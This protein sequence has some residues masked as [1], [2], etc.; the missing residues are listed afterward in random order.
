[1]TYKTLSS[2]PQPTTIYLGITKADTPFPFVIAKP[3]DAFPIRRL[4]LSG[5]FFR[6]EPD[7][8]NSAVMKCG[9]K[10]L[11]SPDGTSSTV[12]GYV[13][14]A[15][16][17]GYTPIVVHQ[18][19]SHSAD[20]EFVADPSFHPSWIVFQAPAP[21]NVTATFAYVQAAPEVATDAVYIAEG[22]NHVCHP[23][24]PPCTVT[25]GGACPVATTPCISPPFLQSLDP[26]IA[27]R[28]DLLS[29]HGDLLFTR[30]TGR[31][32]E[33]P[34]TLTVQLFTG[35]TLLARRVTKPSDDQSLL[36]I[37]MNIMD[38]ETVHRTFGSQIAEHYVAVSLDIANR[39]AKKLQFNKSAVWFDV[40]YSQTSGRY[41]RTTGQT[42][43]LLTADLYPTNPYLT[44]FSTKEPCHINT[45]TGREKTPCQKFRFGIEQNQRVFPVNYTTVLNAFDANTEHLDRILRYVE[46]FGSVLDIVATGGVVAQINNTAFRDSAT[47]FT[48]NFLPGFRSVTQD[49]PG[50]N[51]MRANLVN[52][53]FQEVVQLSANGHAT[54]TVLLPRDAIADYQG[55]EQPVVIDRVLNVH[56]DPDVLNGVKDPPVPMNHVDLGYTKDQVRQSLGEPPNV[57]TAADGTSAYVYSAGPY[58]KVNF[59]KEGQA[60]SWDVRAIKD[61]L[62]AAISLDAANQILRTSNLKATQLLLLNKNTLLVGIDGMDKKLQYDSSGKHVDDYVELYPSIYK[63]WSERSVLISKRCSPARSFQSLWRLICPS[64][65]VTKFL[66]MPCPM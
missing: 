29:V 63:G 18:L 65:T 24:Q 34:E 17:S 11:A 1:V 22:M 41:R 26:G 44:T 6:P 36:N 40:D 7:P 62:V 38:Q 61:Q 42:V 60:I 31:A 53:T 23:P 37:A 66:P 13:Y 2:S 30:V 28:V 52:D 50:T 55:Y 33:L 3:Q 59:N 10:L 21:A 48:A 43:S 16:G 8:A 19:Q 51:R 35:T 27:Q 39:S 14:G 64:R 15:D 5:D 12:T 47:I 20:V 58:A 57:T 56:I 9:S 54:T 49:L 45:Q 46:L 4:V 25:P 32:G